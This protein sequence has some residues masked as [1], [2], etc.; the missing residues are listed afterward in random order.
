MMFD[1]FS[2]KSLNNLQGWRDCG[3]MTS[4]FVSGYNIRILYFWTDVAE[5]WLRRKVVDADSK[6]EATYLR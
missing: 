6:Y 1:K 4:S 2:K 5:I 3:A